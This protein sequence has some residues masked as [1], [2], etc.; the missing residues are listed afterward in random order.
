MCTT[1][2]GQTC[3]TQHDPCTKETSVFR[4]SAKWR[5]I[6]GWKVPDVSNQ[7]AAVILKVKCIWRLRTKTRCSFERYKP[8]T[9]QHGITSHKTR[10]LSVSGNF[11]LHA[12]NLTKP[13][14]INRRN[15]H[16]AWGTEKLHAGFWWGD[17]IERVHLEDVGEDGRTIWKWIFKKWDGEAWTGLVWLRRGTGGGLNAV[18]NLRVP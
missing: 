12:P 1:R 11:S 4:S 18:T 17:L 9:Q 3:V 13:R 7:L 10:I 2:D 5:C 15:M 6:A 14:R 16:H 8:F